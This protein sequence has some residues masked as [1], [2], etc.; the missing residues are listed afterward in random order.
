MLL[1]SGDYHNCKL[2]LGGGLNYAVW[3]SPFFLFRLSRNHTI[4]ELTVQHYGRQ[5]MADLL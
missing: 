2:I 5:A 1:S 4:H 3:Q